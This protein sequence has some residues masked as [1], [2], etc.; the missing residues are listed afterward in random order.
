MMQMIKEKYLKKLVGE[1][2]KIPMIQQDE[3]FVAHQPVLGWIIAHDGPFI[4]DFH[5]EFTNLNIA[6]F[7]M[8]LDFKEN[9]NVDVDI[10][11]LPNQ[12]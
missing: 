6:I 7:G 5:P 12:D 8:A 9:L 4:N 10:S 2:A 1:N 3:Y 11:I